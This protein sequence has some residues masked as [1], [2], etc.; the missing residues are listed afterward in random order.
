[1]KSIVAIAV[2]LLP[3]TSFAASY[4]C[5]EWS[6][7]SLQEKGR[8]TV[9]TTDT[10][11]IWSNGRKAVEAE[12]IATRDNHKI[13]ADSASV[14]FVWEIGNFANIRRVFSTASHLRSSELEC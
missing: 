9:T 1:M 12:L 8:I 6:S 10:A 7:A 4:S 11:L 2:L 5:G 3:T 13:F 14:Y